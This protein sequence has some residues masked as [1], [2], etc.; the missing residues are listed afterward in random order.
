MLK[1]HTCA[2]VDFKE[3]MV[4]NITQEKLLSSDKIRLI[5]RLKKKFEESNFTV[6]QAAENVDKLIV[7]T[8]ISMSSSLN[9]V[10]IEGEDV[11]LL[12]L[13]TSFAKDHSNVFLKKPNKDKSIEKIESP[14]S[15]QFSE[16]ISDNIHFSLCNLQSR[17]DK[18]RRP[19]PPYHKS[20]GGGG[21]FP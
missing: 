18:T 19:P 11:D 10:F 1:N 9:S 3:S 2:D 12:V 15:L 7:N 17:E 14:K 5:S 21:G 8:A 13:L 16:N 20:R 6:K 4:E